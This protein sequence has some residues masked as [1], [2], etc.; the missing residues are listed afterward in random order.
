MLRIDRLASTM[1]LGVREV[2]KQLIGAVSKLSFVPISMLAEKFNPQNT[3]CIISVKF[4]SRLE[5][6]PKS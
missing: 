5:L 3:L 4:F 2:L 6:E 1:R